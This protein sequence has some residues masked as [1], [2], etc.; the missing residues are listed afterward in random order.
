MDL[1]TG[2]LTVPYINDTT[3]T[4]NGIYLDRAVPQHI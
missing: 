2:S 4:L 3:Q 1:W